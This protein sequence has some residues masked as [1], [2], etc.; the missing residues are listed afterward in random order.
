MVVTVLFKYNPH[1]LSPCYSTLVRMSEFEHKIETLYGRRV[2]YKNKDD[3]ERKMSLLKAGGSSKLNI[4]SD[5]DFTLSKFKM[6]NGQR[7]CSCYKIIE[8]CG[9]LSHEYHVQAQ[10]LQLHYYPLEVDPSLDSVTRTSYMI[11][12][13]EK[14]NVLL[15]KSGLSKTIIETAVTRSIESGRFILRPK[16]VEFLSELEERRVPI[17]IFSAGIFDVLD[18]AL[19]YYKA[20][21]HRSLVHV[22]S[23]KPIF[24]GPE[25]SI[26]TF[27]EPVIHVFNKKAETFLT[28]HEYFKQE[29]LLNRTNLILLGDSL[30]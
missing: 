18:S 16:V 15:S 13:V 6:E 27:E 1:R 25:G 14:A 29:D 22:I 4:V 7:G 5:F 2:S 8:D 12:W 24:D 26:S 21:I 9:L 10:A 11:E 17:L 30:G 3:F 23:N 28:T 20:S 19:R